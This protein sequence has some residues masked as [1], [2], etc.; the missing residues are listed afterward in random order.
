MRDS[1]ETS[2]LV[3]E[4]KG[5]FTLDEYRRAFLL[6]LPEEEALHVAAAVAA[7]G[8]SNRPGE[9][10]TYGEELLDDCLILLSFLSDDLHAR[11]ER[12]RAERREQLER[13]GLEEAR[14]AS[15]DRRYERRKE[16]LERK[17]RTEGKLPR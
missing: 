11:V 5:A 14:L 6:L 4:P 13:M 9:R 15:K 8:D 12:F 16:E 17:L 1:I 10:T 7:S 3:P 2:S